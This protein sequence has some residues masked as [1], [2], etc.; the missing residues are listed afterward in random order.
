[1]ISSSMFA[2]KS[3][4]SGSPKSV[5]WLGP[6]PRDWFG[7]AG[8]PMQVTPTPSRT[9]RPE[10]RMNISD[11]EL[12]EPVTRAIKVTLPTP[13]LLFQYM[14]I[15]SHIHLIHPSI[16][17]AI[18]ASQR[19]ASRHEAVVISFDMSGNRSRFEGRPAEGSRP[20]RVK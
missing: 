15:H 11:K 1:M 8:C 14:S 5:G 10:P 7:Q 18:I 20:P 12:P 19:F 6:L 13:T 17:F 3:C 16:A 4:A 9:N 2:G